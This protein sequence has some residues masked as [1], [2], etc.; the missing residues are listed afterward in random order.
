[1]A[2]VY[3][4]GG[5]QTQAGVAWAKVA[6]IIQGLAE[7]IKEETWKMCGTWARFWEK[8]RE[9]GRVHYLHSPTY[10]A[11]S[12]TERAEARCPISRIMTATTEPSTTII[13]TTLAT[14]FI[15]STRA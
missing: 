5:E 10:Q 6:T 2:R 4:A 7:G 9:K 8:S 12:L 14:S 15:P 3:E 13:I 1:M 11:A